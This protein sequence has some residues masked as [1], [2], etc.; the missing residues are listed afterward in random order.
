[1]T[2][3][4]EQD[5]LRR[6]IQGCIF[7]TAV[8]DAIGLPYEGLK[9][10]RIKRL[11]ALPLRHRFFFGI[12]MMS[13]DTEHTC[14]VAQSLIRSGGDPERFA[15]AMMWCLRWWF[16]GLPAGIGMATLRACL[17]M[18]LFV[19]VRWS[20]VFSAGNG[21][22]MRSAI[23]GVYAARDATQRHALVDINTRITHQDP[24]ATRGRRWLP[25]W[26]HAVP[27]VNP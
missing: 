9:P 13:D 14:M 2:N 12:G 3:D 11:H 21:P 22:A 4:H 15:R 26:P 19:P 10:G 5:R 23:I 7:G 16:L 6:A 24:K 20:G 25:S 8:A 18:W 17:K 1:M 27:L